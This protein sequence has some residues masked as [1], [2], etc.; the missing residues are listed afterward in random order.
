MGGNIR[1]EKSMQ[2]LNP[3]QM[4]CFTNNKAVIELINKLH[5]ATPGKGSHLHRGSEKNENGRSLPKSMVG[6]NIVDYQKTPSLFVQEN[7]A[8]T[9]VKELYNEAIMKRNN[10]QF[11]GNGQKI[12][13]EPDEK[14]Y[15]IVRNIKIQRQGSYQS[16]GKTI[17]K[18]YPWTVTIQ[19]GKG[20][21][22]AGNNQGG[23]SCKKG[24]FILE[25]EAS[26]NMSDGDFFALFE[27]AY[28][29]ITAWE[30]YC[31]HAFN[32]AN[33]EAIIKAEEQWKNNK[34]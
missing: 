13:G 27:E 31:A 4:S 14:G 15:S 8:P 19:N 2:Q 17:V 21:K 6:I 12:F 30:S 11:S 29:Y 28:T 33:E 16:N 26:I 5:M 9:Q 10:Y 3:R 20:I 32:K 22:E 23:M 1:R 18:N 25:K 34:N 7:L 24:S